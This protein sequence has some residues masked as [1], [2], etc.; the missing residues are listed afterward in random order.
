MIKFDIAKSIEFLKVE[1]EM[2]FQE[3]ADKIGISKQSISQMQKIN[4]YKVNTLAVYADAL[5]FDV[6]IIFTNK[7]TGNQIKAIK[8]IN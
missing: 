4:N 6:D 5:G 1:S 7:E 2:T 8:T 3:V